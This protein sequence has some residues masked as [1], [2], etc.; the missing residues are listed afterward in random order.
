MGHTFGDD[1]TQRSS[2]TSSYSSGPA[3]VNLYHAHYWVLVFRP[4]TAAT[5]SLDSFP[6]LC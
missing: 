1:N 4:I 6:L 3:S 5:R 2:H